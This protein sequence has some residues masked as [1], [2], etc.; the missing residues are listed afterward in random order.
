MSSVLVLNQDFSPLTLSSVER[1]FLLIY[2]E[3]AEMLD[4]LHG[5][6]LRTVSN[7]YPC[8]SVIRIL[9]YKKIP[10]KGV[11]LTRHNLFKRDGFQC[12]YCGTSSN[13]TLDHVQPKSRGGKSTWANLV[14]ACKQCN[15]R[16][17]DANPEEIQMKLRKKPV[18]PSYIV[19]LKSSAGRLQQDWLKYLEPKAYA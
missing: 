8:P 15:A 7:S 12:Q 13:L 9:D 17:G 4:V 10:Y 11:V 2:L 18:K 16:K 19:Y 14:T 3:K 1:A 5:K 6:V